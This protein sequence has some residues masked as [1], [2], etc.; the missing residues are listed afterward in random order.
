[1]RT[2][3]QGGEGGKAGLMMPRDYLQVLAKHLGVMAAVLAASVTLFAIWAFRAAP[4][5]RAE[6]RLH[7]YQRAPRVVSIEEV[8]PVDPSVSNYHKTQVEIIR[9]RKVAKAVFQSLHLEED[10]SFRSSRDGVEAFRRG[11]QVRPKKNTGI[12]EVAYEGRDPEKITLWVKEV[13]N[14]Y[15]RYHASLR[16]TTTAG[17]EQILKDRIPELGRNLSE[18]ERALEAFHRENDIVTFEKAHTSLLERMRVLDL[19]LADT[20]MEVAALSAAWEGIERARSEGGD[21]QSLPALWANDAIQR[22]RVQEREAAEELVTARTK[23][24]DREGNRL[25]DP[26]RIRM[27]EVEIALEREVEIAL[28]AVRAEYL[29]KVVEEGKL[30][31]LIGKTKK[32]AQEL[33]GLTTR[34]AE[35]KAEVDRDRRIYEDVAGRATE[36]KGA[37]GLDL[38]SVAIL[39]EAEVP[40]APIWPRKGLLLFLGVLLGGIGGIGLAFLLEYMDESV[41]TAED[42]GISLNLP[43]LGHVPRIL[44]KSGDLA[45]RDL[46][47]HREPRSTISEF[48]RTIRTGLL[49]SHPNGE[50]KSLVVTS[51][52]PKEGKTTN[53]INLAITMAAGGSR[54]LLVDGDLRRS[55][56]HSA[57]EVDNRQGLATF[58][59]GNA[60]FDDVVIPS[61]DVKDLWLCPSGPTPSQPAELLGSKRMVEFLKEAS[62]KFD[63]VILDSPPVVAVTDACVLAS[64]TDGVIQVVASARSSRKILERGKDQLEAVGARIVGVILNDVKMKRSGYGY[65]YGYKYGS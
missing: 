52:G 21:L 28:E 34:Y 19:K 27:R 24:V 14:E 64:I 23:Y 5:Y 10:D 62:Q 16:R 9:S 32:E 59:G 41:R 53:A 55:R 40:G 54:V 35:F 57:F 46:I 29:Q 22:L 6:S 45:G 51:A 39:D 17:A 65:G 33:E 63:R 4:I 18:S 60:S 8:L 13:V 49:Y 37:A 47:S 43:L 30:H 44:T 3:N 31:D 2:T 20:Q 58:L 48:F 7:I 36:M 61:K 26:Y 15:L 25:L 11:V 56:I 12:I 50:I 42:V 38:N 1:M